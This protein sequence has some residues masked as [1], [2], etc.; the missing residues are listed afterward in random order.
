VQP[1]RRRTLA[2]QGYAGLVTGRGGRTLAGNF[3]W[4]V[5]GMLVAIGVLEIGKQRLGNVKGKRRTGGQWGWRNW[6]RRREE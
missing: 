1:P 5:D 2:R 4:I 6:V 3:V